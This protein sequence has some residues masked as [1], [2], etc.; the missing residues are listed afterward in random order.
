LLGLRC[1]WQGAEQEAQA[2]ASEAYQVNRRA[3]GGS[4]RGF[5][6]RICLVGMHDYS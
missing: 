4:A 6:A 3:S 5:P 2:Q 1:G